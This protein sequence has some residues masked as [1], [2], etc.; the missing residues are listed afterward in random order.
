M[1]HALTGRV[2]G[3]TPS[4]IIL[5]TGAIHW[6][7]EASAPTIRTVMSRRGEEITVYTYLQSRDD[8][9]TLFGFATEGERSLFFDLIK[10]DGIGAKQ[11]IRILS[12]T[13][14]DRFLQSVE[15]GDIDSLIHIKGLGR[16]TAQKI[17]LAMQGRLVVSPGTTDSSGKEPHGEILEALVEM[18]YDRRLARNALGRIAEELSKIRMPDN[19]REQELF[20]RSIIELS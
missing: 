15:E 14:V 2:E 10:V 5:V 19:E 8:G 18:G 4:A 3:A 16:K 6:Q 13:T 12:G 9:I 17:L 1:I 11:A 7:I 20:R